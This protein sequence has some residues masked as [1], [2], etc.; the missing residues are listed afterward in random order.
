MMIPCPVCKQTGKPLDKY[1]RQVHWV[2]GKYE[3]EVCW[4]CHNEKYVEEVPAT[5]RVHIRKYHNYVEV[6]NVNQG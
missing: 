3:E 2:D 6:D 5:K 1:S 4:M